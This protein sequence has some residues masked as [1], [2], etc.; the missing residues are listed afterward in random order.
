MNKKTKVFSVLLVLFSVCMVIANILA[1]KMIQL[2]PITVTAGILIFP[3]TYILGDTFVEVYGYKTARFVIWVGFAA[4][5]LAVI[6]FNL[7][8]VLPSPIWY[9]GSEAF[10]ATLGS[11][12]RIVCAGLIAYL[13]GSFVNAKIMTKLKERWPSQLF[14]RC[15]TSTV[16][17]EF[18]DSC[19]FITAAFAFVMPY[20]ELIQMIFVQATFKS[21]YEAVIYPVNRT[22]I[23]RLKT[24]EI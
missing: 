1:A 23:K 20:Q 14:V 8:I 18:L 17:G 12:A 10:K 24:V 21:I 15:I 2:G 19:I 5:I 6:F 9:E 16:A 4:N 13:I 7:A 11:T 22:V 3:I